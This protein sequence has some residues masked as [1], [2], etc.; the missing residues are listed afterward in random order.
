[1]ETTTT[2]Y[3]FFMSMVEARPKLVT[4]PIF[5]QAMCDAGELPSEGMECLI[6][7]CAGNDFFN[8]FDGKILTIICHTTNTNGDATAAFSYIDEEGDMAYHAFLPHKFK[9][10]TPPKT[11]T[12]KAVDDMASFVGSSESDFGIIQA[13]KD[14]KIH[15]VTF[16]GES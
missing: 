15:G 8:R 16:K 3:D 7:D 6:S 14:G 9:P 10:L 11:D 4:S 1:M 2:D 12:E 13:I 5:T